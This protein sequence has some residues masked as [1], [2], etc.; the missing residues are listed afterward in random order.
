MIHLV[1]LEQTYPEEEVLSRTAID[2]YRKFG[3]DYLV[4]EITGLYT[5]SI[6]P[7]DWREK[8]ILLISH[9]C[10]RFRALY[11][12]GLREI[13]IELDDSEPGLLEDSVQIFPLPEVPILEDL[14]YKEYHLREFGA[15]VK[16]FH[17]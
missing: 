9:G 8:T 16:G 12:L 5:V 11:E 4:R 2:H 1:R 3:I 6:E 17:Y 10:H 13:R 14:E 15:P 7:T